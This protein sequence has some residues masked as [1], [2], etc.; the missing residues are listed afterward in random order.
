MPTAAMNQ[1]IHE[2][3]RSAESAREAIAREDWGNAQRFLK[4]ALDRTGRLLRD[5]GD[6]SHEV[7]RAP[8]VDR[9]DRG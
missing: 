4:D 8:K 7:M 2:V 3:I 1:E 6:K 9:A 5:V